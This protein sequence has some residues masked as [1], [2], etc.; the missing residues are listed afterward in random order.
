VEDLLRALADVDRHGEAALGRELDEQAA[1]PP[2][3]VVREAAQH[4]LALL[5][6]GLGD[7]GGD[8]IRRGH[9]A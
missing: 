5:L 2:R 8:V 1:E 9:G 4:E 3:V 7:Q 6:L